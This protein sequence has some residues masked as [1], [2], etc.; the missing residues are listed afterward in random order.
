[1]EKIPQPIILEGVKR[2]DE[3]CEHYCYDADDEHRCAISGRR[4]DPY[5]GEDCP[6]QESP[7]L[8]EPAVLADLKKL[9]EERNRAQY[10]LGRSLDYTRQRAKLEDEPEG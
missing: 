4:V 1:M 9:T 8:C 6:R 3:A 10:L 2:C 5:L 7:S